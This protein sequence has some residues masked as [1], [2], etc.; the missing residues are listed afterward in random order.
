[1]KKKI[2]L[3]TGLCAAVLALSLATTTLADEHTTPVTVPITERQD[4]VTPVSA[5]SENSATTATNE[6]TA[7]LP[8]EETAIPTVEESTPAPAETPV[9][10]RISEIRVIHRRRTLKPNF[11]PIASSTDVV[12][13][14]VE[15]RAFT[16]YD[17][18]G[19]GPATVTDENGKTWY[20][21]R[22]SELD[23]KDG[24]HY[25]SAPEKGTA[26]GPVI[27]V[28]HFYDDINLNPE[29][30]KRARYVDEN[31]QEIAPSQENSVERSLDLAYEA[32]LPTAP[33]QIQANGKT[34]TFQSANKEELTSHKLH[35]SN[36]VT[37]TYFYKEVTSPVVEKPVTPSAPEKHVQ[38]L[39]LPKGNNGVKNRVPVSKK[40]QAKPSTPEVKKFRL[41]KG[42]NGT[43]TRV[44]VKKANTILSVDYL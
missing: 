40:T 19:N 43:K 32:G 44:P 13:K 14:T 34:Y 33:A 16:E 24:F 6:A 35:V 20:R 27:E 9:D 28:I 26:T 25:K 17:V 21:V 18:S 1:M 30:I 10:P 12:Y 29:V 8:S 15:A 22:Y 31:G 37:V 38:K 39:R 2:Q 36:L 11:S 41:P 4:T 7:P 3:T 23:I 5:T 42:N